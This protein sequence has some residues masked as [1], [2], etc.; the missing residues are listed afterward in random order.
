VREEPWRLSALE[1]ARRI[2]A[3][4][5]TSAEVVEALLERIARVNPHLNAVTLVLADEARAGARA[6]DR[7]VDAGARLGP[8]HGVPFTIKENVDV[9]G[10]PTTMGV[11]ALAEAIPAID[12]P[13]VERLRAAGAIPIA[14]TNLPDM[15]LRV[16]TSSSLRG[17]TR[18]PWHPGRTA[19]GSSG[20]EA[21]A[22]A[23]GMTPL[24]LG[25]DIG[26]SLRNPAHCCGVASLKPTTGRVPWA[27]VVPA[28]DGPP[29]QQ[30]MH[31][32][33]P[34]ARSVADLRAALAVLAGPHPRDPFA[35][36]APLVGPRPAERLRVAVLAEPP[37][38]STAP[39]IAA[40]VDRA[41]RALAAAGCEVAAATP[42]HFDRIPE[43]WG[44]WLMSELRTMMPMLGPVMGEEALGFLQAVDRQF[45]AMDLGAL[46]GV[47]IERHAIA[48]AWSQFFTEH[49]VILSPVWTTPPFE[50]GWD[51]ACDENVAEVL[52]TIRCVLPANFLG[53]P[54]A[55]VPAA[56]ADGLPVGV[57]L[58]GNRFR[59]DLCLE[60]AEAIERALGV[61][62]PIDPVTD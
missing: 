35:V 57:Q 47:L 43:I 52:T 27:A 10:S 26:G 58:L 56:L 2:A 9:A 3:R 50:H 16:H 11:R 48:R 20:G 6:A 18:N 13:V 23:T 32:E 37:G 39:E 49:D 15:G 61:L 51:T 42:P 25:N 38:G 62:T 8:F 19:G 33:G 5:L 28:E 41:A 36:P 1:L 44:A 53:L 30:L 4:E 40:G 60:A 12:A 21:A 22:L 14:R 31:V 46:N 55:V 29:S 24:G 54:A 45:P 17:V 34:M 7:A 59:E